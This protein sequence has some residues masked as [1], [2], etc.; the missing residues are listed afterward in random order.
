MEFIKDMTC[1]VYDI[2]N[3]A[4]DNCRT[5]IFHLNDNA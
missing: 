5:S 4:L 2:I 3:I 1:Y